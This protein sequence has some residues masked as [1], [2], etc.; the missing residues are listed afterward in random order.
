MCYLEQLYITIYCIYLLPVYIY[1]INNMIN[2][3]F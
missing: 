3:N 1:N 2:N